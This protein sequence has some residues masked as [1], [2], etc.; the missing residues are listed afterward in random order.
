MPKDQF[1][2]DA[3]LKEILKEANLPAEKRAIIEETFKIEPVA[4]ELARSAIS[5]STF[6]RNQQE[7]AEQ[8]K[9]LEAKEKEWLSW[10]ERASSEAAE[11]AAEKEKLQ[12]EATEIRRV[13]EQY[14]QTY[15]ELEGA[16]MPPQQQLDPAQYVSRKDY[17]AALR[18]QQ[19][20]WIKNINLIGET[21]TLTAKY[22]KEF[23]SD[24]EPLDMNAVLQKAT[25]EGLNVVQ[26]YEA[27][28]APLRH[29]REEAKWTKKLEEAREEGRRAAL[30]G[31][32]LPT[33]PFGSEKP[34]PIE[35]LTA[36]DG[37]PLVAGEAWK[38]ALQDLMEGK[39][40]GTSVP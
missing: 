37:K 16:Q 19:E 29:V 9:T 40:E 8:R 12:K 17:E 15:G 24:A 13:A 28:V 5:H 23:G 26:A 14:K 27:T 32:K 36:T 18:S 25:A 21:Q 35:G 34:H 39:L 31:L 30:S 7:L 1:D 4:R 6:S 11:V 33:M 10:Y 38:V 20:L 2:V 22:I 3:Y